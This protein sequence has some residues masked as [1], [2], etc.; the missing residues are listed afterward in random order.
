MATK[1]WRSAITFTA[2]A[3]SAEAGGRKPSPLARLGVA[4]ELD[5][6]RAGGQATSVLDRIERETQRLGHLIGELLTLTRLEDGG[7]AL[8]RFQLC[9]YLKRQNVDVESE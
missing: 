6:Q 1:G 3:S 4:L 2:A 7:A 9:T 8:S 5:R